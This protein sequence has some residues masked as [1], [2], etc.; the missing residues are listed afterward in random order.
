L[1]VDLAD[2]AIHDMGDFS[3]EIAG[4]K[5]SKIINA[6]KTPIVL[7]GE[8]SISPVIVSEIND[9]SLLIFDAHLDFRDEYEG[10]K[11][12]HA[13]T[14][15]RLSEIVGP[16]N[17]IILGVRSMCGDELADAGN[18]GLRFI[19][20]EDEQSQSLDNVLNI[21]DERL[22]NRI[23]ISLDMD[24]IDPAYAPGVGTPEPFGLPPLYVRDVLRHIAEK[25]VGF[26]I[27]EVCPPYDNG[28]TSSLAA[29]LLRDFIG[30]REKS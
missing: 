7:G 13:C 5:V 15:R 17:I 16:E 11:N 27:V 9:I 18:T 25:V 24:V 4:S 26:D 10:K 22:G 21:I 20:A 12:N 2:V 3:I 1:G 28:N 23:Y 30:A 8:H 14:I 6:G 19:T 29:K